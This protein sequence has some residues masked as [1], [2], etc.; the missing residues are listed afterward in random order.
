MH[1]PIWRSKHQHIARILEV[2]VRF[3]LNLFVLR[4]INNQDSI[5]R[6]SDV[7]VIADRA[8]RAE[9]TKAVINVPPFQE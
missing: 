5:T 7:T 2:V 6:F 1:V 4:S 3:L 9:T 8:E